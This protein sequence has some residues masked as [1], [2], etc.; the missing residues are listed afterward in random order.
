[1][2]TDSIPG[3]ILMFDGRQNDLATF[4]RVNGNAAQLT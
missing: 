3:R 2:R 4:I 1:M